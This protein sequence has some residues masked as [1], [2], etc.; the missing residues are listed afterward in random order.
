[1]NAEIPEL[2]AEKKCANP[3]CKVSE[4]G[5]CIEGLSF[6]DCPTYGRELEGQVPPDEI[7]QAETTVNLVSLQSGTSLQL[8]R[9]SELLGH[10]DG[11]VVA[12]VGPRDAG[13]TS[14]IASLFDLF[15]EG[16]IG[17]VAFSGSETLHAFE[18]ACHDSRTASRRTTPVQERTGHG[19]VRFYHL[20][21]SVDSENSNMT[22]LLGD[23]AGEQYRTASDDLAQAGPFPE[24]E[25]ANTVTVLVDGG[26]LL[27][28]TTRHNTRS[29]IGMIMRA[30]ADNNFLQ[31]SPRIIF[32]LTKLDLINASE[33]KDR[34][35]AD[36]DRVVETSTRI[37]A[38][39]SSSTHSA[40]IAAAPNDTSLSRGFG[41]E[42]L[43]KLWV[44]PVPR[45]ASPAIDKTPAARAILNLRMPA[46]GNGGAV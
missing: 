5:R 27:D 22:L 30:M 33:H 11:R 20:K 44:Q 17:T 32:A 43:L 21:L 14:L 37:V 23:R 35:L 36:F 10:Q 40:H 42:A 45:S 16:P 41:V 9:A 6:E 31:R 13:K 24:V 15:Q 8:E 34:A 26:R 39:Y 25:R 38:A 1:M 7:E 4:N 19:N 12:I 28:N 18:L 46:S 2:T 3:E 29:E